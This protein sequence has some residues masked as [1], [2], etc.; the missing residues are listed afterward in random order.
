MSFYMAICQ[1][2]SGYYVKDL[3]IIFRYRI[4]LSLVLEMVSE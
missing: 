1:N 4:E 3:K 2:I